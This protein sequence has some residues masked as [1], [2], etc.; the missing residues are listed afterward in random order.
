MHTEQPRAL[1]LDH[2][3]KT[4]KF[5][6]WLCFKC[7]TGLARFG[8]SLEGIQ[9]AYNYLKRAYKGDAE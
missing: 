3:H 4:G 8:D 9:N 6:G 5:R 7:N 2:C 1:A